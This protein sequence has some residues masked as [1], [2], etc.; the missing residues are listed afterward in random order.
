MAASRLG[1]SH[2]DTVSV[3]ARAPVAGPAA[4]TPMEISMLAKRSNGIRGCNVFRIDDMVPL[5]HFS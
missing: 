2:V 3:D 4:V 5:L 1:S